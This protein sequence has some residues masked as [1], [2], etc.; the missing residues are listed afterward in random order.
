MAAVTCSLPKVGVGYFKSWRIVGGGTASQ[1]QLLVVEFPYFIF[2]SIPTA[3][4]ASCPYQ[5]QI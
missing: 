4:E 2:K 1:Q 5:T 3:L